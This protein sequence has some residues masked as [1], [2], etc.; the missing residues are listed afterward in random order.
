MFPLFPLF[1]EKQQQ[2]LNHF[3]YTCLK[4]VLFCLHWS[5]NFFAFVSN[6]ISLE[7]RCLRYWDK[8]FAALAETTDGELIFEQA[9][10]NALREGWLRNEN[11][12]KGVFRSKRYVEHTSLLEKYSRWCAS[13]ASYES[14]PNYNLEEVMVLADFPDTF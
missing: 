6:E 11:S 7:D 13:V 14:V 12:I 10:L 1:T 8:Y 3:Y 2:D 5:D 4:R 9:N